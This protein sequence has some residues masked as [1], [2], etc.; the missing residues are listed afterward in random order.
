M[1]WSTLKYLFKEGIVGLWRNRTMALA[2]IGTI[3]LCLLIL[4]MSY[5]IGTNIDYLIEQIETK[6]GI[7]AYIQEG[8]TELEI[9]NLRY[10]VEKMTDVASV[11]YISKEE[12]LK[13]FSAD[14]EDESLFKMFQDDNPLPASLEITTVDIKD[15]AQLIE[16][17]NN[18][19]GID[20]TVYF[21]NETQTFINIRNT[22]NYV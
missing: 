7:T 22:V 5:G 12:A 11:T 1:K 14:N 2:S 20:E 17:L 4:G 15:Q 18:L 21:Q 16:K 13:N 3:V 19:E 10:E 9:I 6:F 8:L